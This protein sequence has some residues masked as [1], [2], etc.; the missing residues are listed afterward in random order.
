MN[1]DDI[2]E[3][4]RRAMKELAEAQEPLGEE[5][6]RVLHENLEKLYLKNIEKKLTDKEAI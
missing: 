1:R 4:V 6:E 2:E 5:F 3:R